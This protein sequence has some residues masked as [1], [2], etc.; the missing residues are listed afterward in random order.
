MRTMPGIAVVTD[1]SKALLPQSYAQYPR[2][3]WSSAMPRTDF[4]AYDSWAGFNFR[5]MI[6]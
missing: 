2:T 1:V 3:R 6:Q 5:H 4:T